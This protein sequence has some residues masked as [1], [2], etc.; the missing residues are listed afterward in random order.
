MLYN[1]VCYNKFSRFWKKDLIVSTIFTFMVAFKEHHFP[2]VTDICRLNVTGQKASARVSSDRSEITAQQRGLN[3]AFRQQRL[4]LEL[5][6]NDSQWLHQTHPSISEQIYCFH[7]LDSKP[8]QIILII[9]IWLG[10]WLIS[11]HFL[12]CNKLS[13]YQ[14]TY[15]FSLTWRKTSEMKWKIFTERAWKSHLSGREPIST[16]DTWQL[17]SAWH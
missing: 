8:L 17:I 6:N 12:W 15:C 14:H 1:L 2:W 4:Q 9:E 7:Y 10:G 11:E 16:A 5:W 13:T 3:D